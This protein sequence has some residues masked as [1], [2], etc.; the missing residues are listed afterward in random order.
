MSRQ[1]VE[2]RWRYEK[3]P[4]QLRLLKTLKYAL[5]FMKNAQQ[6]TREDTLTTLTKIFCATLK[7]LL[8]SSSRFKE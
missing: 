5:K 7:K 4:L 3:N 2:G 8:K 1:R 6:H